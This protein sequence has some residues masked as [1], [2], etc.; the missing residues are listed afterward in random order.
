MPFIKRRLV[1]SV[2]N[3]FKP[4]WLI[5]LLVI[6]SGCQ[7]SKVYKLMQDGSV[8]QKE[9]LVTVP[10]EMRG[11]LCFIEV[12]VNGE[13]GL[14]LFDTGAPNIVSE[15]FAERLSL[16]TETQGGVK[17]SGGNRTKGNAFVRLEDINIGGVHF[18]NTGA[19]VQN[20]SSSDIFDCMGI[21]GIIGANLMRKA[22]WKIDYKE[23][24]IGFSSNLDDFAVDSTYQVLPFLVNMTGTPVVD[25]SFGGETVNGMTFDT[26]SNKEFS[27][28]LKSLRAAQ[29]STPITTTWELGAT[30][31]GVGGKALA[32]TIFYAVIDTMTLGEL[33][34][35]NSVVS[36][37]VHSDNFGNAFL[38][39]Y[40]V[41]LNWET[42]QIYMKPITTYDYS[43][44]ETHGYGVNLVNGNIEIGSLY[45]G[46]PA[47]GNLE[48]G[49]RILQ[50]DEYN[51]EQNPS[52]ICEMVN[53]RE[54]D[55]K[56]RDSIEMTIKRGEE[57]L[58]LTLAKMTLL[59][60]R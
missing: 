25:I 40:D 35:L 22:F 57:T 1:L 39:H 36:F 55:F 10:F 14:F 29:K 6:L 30:S 47:D 45:N 34:I 12:E 42:R 5:L 15:P 60:D 7:G 16:E 48:I 43:A 54:V 20:L 3:A 28:P 59:G 33:S 2:K 46:S 17:D 27:M 56:K 32:D 19:V 13:K 58:T 44:L 51:F 9:F 53:A 21:D 52:L 38:E 24:T 49:D 18:M 4:V 8:E 11:G 23:E 50:I 31:Y 37:D 41:V 26:G